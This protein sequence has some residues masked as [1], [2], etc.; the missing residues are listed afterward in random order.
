M[1]L[2]SNNLNPNQFRMT[3]QQGQCEGERE[4]VGWFEGDDDYPIAGHIRYE[5]GP[6]VKVS[7]LHVEAARRR[8]GVA[9][10]IFSHLE[11]LYG[12]EHIDTGEG[13]PDGKA[14]YPN[15]KK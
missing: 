3:E 2:V 4:V 15:R 12:A 5:P 7:A 13:T 8:L 14:W 9:S 11:S 6:V 1:S 10:K